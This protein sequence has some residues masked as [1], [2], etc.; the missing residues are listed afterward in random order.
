MHTKSLP[1]CSQAFR[2]K[3]KRLLVIILLV[4]ISIFINILVFVIIFVLVLISTLLFCLPGLHSLPPPFLA[5][6]ILLH[7]LFVLL[8]VL[9]LV[10]PFHLVLVPIFED[11]YQAQPSV[12]YEA[13]RTRLL[14]HPPLLLS[15]HPLL[16][17][18]GEVPF[19]YFLQYLNFSFWLSR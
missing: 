19:H 4:I 8:L 15:V 6:F 18:H 14:P 10:L 3:V 2:H 1:R 12:Q 5:L 7:L 11:M 16:F 13:E 17:I 9:V